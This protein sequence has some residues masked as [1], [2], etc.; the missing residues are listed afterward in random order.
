M[1]LNGVSGAR[2]GNSLNPPANTT[3]RMADSGATAPS[4]GPFKASE[5]DVQ[6]KRRSARERAADDVEV[7]LDR[8]ARHRFYNQRAAAR[9]QNFSRTLCRRPPDRPCRAGNR[10]RSTMSNCSSGSSLAFAT[11]KVTR[12][13]T[14]ASAARWRAV[15]IGLLVI[16]ETPE[17]RVRI[18]LR[19]DD[20]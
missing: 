16:V 13:E 12:S 4:A 8:V 6:H 7:F 2:G 11:A 14:P 5:F 3:S 9:S 15:A 10:R 18:G 20:C 17:A 19:H 1:R